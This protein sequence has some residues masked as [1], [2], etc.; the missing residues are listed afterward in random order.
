MLPIRSGKFTRSYYH[1]R[2]SFSRYLNLG[3]EL[4]NSTSHLPMFQCTPFTILLSLSPILSISLSISSL[5]GPRGF[6]RPISAVF[7]LW[8]SFHLLFILI[9]N[10]YPHS[11][12]LSPRPSL[13]SLSALPLLSL[14]LSQGYILIY[15]EGSGKFPPLLA[16]IGIHQ[17]ATLS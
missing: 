5:G 4:P 7:S 11:W 10:Y 3:S 17:H 6:P 12:P 1:N 15:P 14:Y 2:L 9:C 8:Q 13:A 16:W